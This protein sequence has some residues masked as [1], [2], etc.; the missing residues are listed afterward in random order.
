MV[1]RKLAVLSDTAQS[2]SS[3]TEYIRLTNPVPYL[4]KEE[5]KKKKIENVTLSKYYLEIHL[6]VN[7]IR[8]YVTR[9]DPEVFKL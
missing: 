1:Y 9:H 3:G 7:H 6:N 8:Y 5:K 2:F 4:E